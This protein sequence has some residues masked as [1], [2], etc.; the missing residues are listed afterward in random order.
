MFFSFFWSLGYDSLEKA[1][2]SL[3]RGD[4]YDFGGVGASKKTGIE[5]E[6]KPKLHETIYH[7]AVSALDSQIQL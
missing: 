2:A 5:T 4:K 7:T 1:S 6:T 3:H